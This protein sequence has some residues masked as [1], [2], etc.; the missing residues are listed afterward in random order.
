M[1]VRKLLWQVLHAILLAV[2]NAVL[3][4]RIRNW[5]AIFFEDPCILLVIDRCP[6]ENVQEIWLTKMDFVRPNA[7]IGQKMANG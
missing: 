7:E 1:Y 5:S 4:I 2:Y 3:E 6:I